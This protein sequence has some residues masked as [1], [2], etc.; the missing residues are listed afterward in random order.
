MNAL[1]AVGEK[2]KNLKT[3]Y[4]GHRKI[5]TFYE[6]IILLK[7]VLNSKSKLK[8]GVFKESLGYDYSKVDLNSLY[9]DA[10]FECKADFEESFKKTIDWLLA[11]GLIEK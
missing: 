6:N 5:P 3:Y 9:E 7:K 8:F 2:G 4:L 11:E 1:I 10:G